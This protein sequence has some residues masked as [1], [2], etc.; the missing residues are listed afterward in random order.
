MSYN[1][2]IQKSIVLTSPSGFEFTGKWSGDSRSGSKQLG[3]FKTPGIKG[4][5]AQDLDIDGITYSIPIF[6]DGEDYDFDGDEFFTALGETGVWSFVHPVWGQKQ[7]MQVVSFTQPLELATGVIQ[8]TIE[9]LEVNDGE[10]AKSAQQIA[11]EVVSQNIELSV[12]TADQLDQVVTLDTADKIGKFKT[13]VENAV[14]AFDNTLQTITQTV[15]EVQAQVDSIKRGIDATLSATVVDVLS[16]AGQIQ[17]LVNLPNLVVTDLKA[18]LETYQRFADG[19][20]SFSPDSDTP[21]NINTASVLEIATVSALG[22]AGVAAATTE[23]KSRQNVIDNIE[24]NL[25]LFESVVN[26]LDAIQELYSDNLLSRSYFS[27][28]QSFADSARLSGLTV[29]F[30]IKSAFDLAV[31]KRIILTEWSS[32]SMIALREYGGP[33][34][35]DENI[36]LFYDSNE[37][38]DQETYLLPAGREVVVYL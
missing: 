21:A 32:P 30:L 3:V 15:A 35:N 16:V 11:A 37:L 18:K 22:A 28:S 12:T 33:G 36:D 8:T 9:F 20:F 29:G 4:N 27:Q 24:A 34:L 26:G 1:D 5:I 31:E 10:G 6:F 25:D 2:R 19:V 7:N 14:T 13:A 38:T 23:L 17:A